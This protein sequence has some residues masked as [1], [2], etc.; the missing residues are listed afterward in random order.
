M[1]LT[2]DELER[3]V[4]RLAQTDRAALD[5][6]Y[7]EPGGLMRLVRGIVGES[8]VPPV[9]P[10]APPRDERAELAWLRGLLAD[11]AG[12]FPAGVRSNALAAARAYLAEHPGA[13]AP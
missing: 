13:A 5:A 7:G 6:A 12:D 1:P 9:P 11:L 3:L 8:A 10:L 4:A 2:D